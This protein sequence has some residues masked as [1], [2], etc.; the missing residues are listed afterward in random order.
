LV[1]GREKVRDW[2]GI[3]IPDRKRRRLGFASGNTMAVG[4]NV[5][6]DSSKRPCED[7]DFANRIHE[8]IHGRA[9]RRGKR[10]TEPVVEFVV[11]IR[12]VLVGSY[13]I[14][15]PRGRKESPSIHWKRRSLWK[16]SS[17]LEWSGMTHDNH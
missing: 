9:T 6:V 14:G 2:L 11:D 1:D 10:S 4:S 16:L 5:S 13:G 7:S 12:L 17:R 3:W 15:S 8:V